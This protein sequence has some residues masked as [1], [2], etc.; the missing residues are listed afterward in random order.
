MGKRPCSLPARTMAGTE[1]GGWD[2]VPDGAVPICT[3]PAPSPLP[4]TGPLPPM[5]PPATPAPPGSTSGAGAPA[6][7]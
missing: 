5:P 2:P 4:G 7:P 3:P 6:T 1:T